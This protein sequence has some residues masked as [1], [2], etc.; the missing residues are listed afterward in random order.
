MTLIKMQGKE[1]EAAQWEVLLSPG[2][3]LSPSN[4]QKAKVGA[5]V[6]SE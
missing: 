5:N 2:L 4:K 3:D 6:K 1:L